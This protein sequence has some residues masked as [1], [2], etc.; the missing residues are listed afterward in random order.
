MTDDKDKNNARPDT[1]VEVKVKGLNEKVF[2]GDPDIKEEDTE[3][4]NEEAAEDLKNAESIRAEYEQKLKEQEDQ[5]LRLA[6]EFDNFRKRT[7]RQFE[8]MTIAS[9]ER[10]V[11]PL[12]EVVDNF[13]RALEAASSENGESVKKGMELIYQQLQDVLKREELEEIEA[14]GKPFD[15]NLHDAIMQV[16]SDEYDEGIVVQEL[17]KGYKLKGKVIRHARVAVSKGK[18]EA[19]KPE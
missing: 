18:P 12:L 19:N 16:E 5:F 17:L 2:E 13:H 8:N 15:P 14:V 10:I 7:A 11:L 6:A 9:V 1:K 3:V 4:R